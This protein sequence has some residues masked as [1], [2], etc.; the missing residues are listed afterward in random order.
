M[1][2]PSDI[3]QVVSALADVIRQDREET[4]K[5]TL[6]RLHYTVCDD[7]EISQAMA[8]RLLSRTQV[9][10]AI[11]DGV[12]YREVSF[13]SGKKRI[14]FNYDDIMKLRSKKRLREQKL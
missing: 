7:A 6:K 10:R 8:S 13:P 2:T 11:A 9:E 12:P 3:N 4:I 1:I 5:T 14:Y